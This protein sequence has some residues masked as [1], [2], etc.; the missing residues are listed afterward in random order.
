M[1]DR[2]VTVVHKA[3]ALPLSS[4]GAGQQVNGLSQVAVAD[5]VLLQEGMFS[6]VEQPAVVGWHPQGL[7]ALVDDAEQRLEV[8]P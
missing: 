1:T 3:E 7:A 8:V 2:E 6:G 4:L 5:G